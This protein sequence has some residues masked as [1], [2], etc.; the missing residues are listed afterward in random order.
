VG[1][2]VLGDT[3]C[4]T[5]GHFFGI[6][7]Y[8][9]LSILLDKDI[10]FETGA[11]GKMP[12]VLMG[13]CEALRNIDLVPDAVLSTF[14]GIAGDVNHHVLRCKAKEK[15]KSLVKVCCVSS[16]I[17]IFVVSLDLLQQI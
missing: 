1:V 13:A 2:L 5:G 15:M 4:G 11:N 14:V 9:R 3:K 6:K 17:I 8:A 16:I 12:K 7:N 10:H